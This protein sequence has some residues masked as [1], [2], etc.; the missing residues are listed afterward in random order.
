MGLRTRVFTGGQADLPALAWAALLFLPGIQLPFDKTPVKC[1][2][3]LWSVVGPFQYPNTGNLCTH[4]D[5]GQVN[6]EG[7]ATRSSILGWRIPCTKE[8]GRLQ[9][10]GLQSG[11]LK[12]PSM[13]AHNA[14]FSLHSLEGTMCRQG[15]GGRRP[16]RERRQC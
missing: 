16:F 12:R 14:R 9:S 2:H 4:N 13:H 3:A 11:T 6:E 10:I 7:L 8:P 15:D 5:Q 1:A